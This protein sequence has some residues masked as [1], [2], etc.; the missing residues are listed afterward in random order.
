MSTLHNHKSRKIAIGADHAGFEL[1]EKLK[2][3]LTEQGHTV[4]DCG[5]FST[6]S[7]DYPVIAHQVARLI[8]GAEY[9]LGIIVDGAGI[10]SSMAANKVPGVRAALCHDISTARN[11]REHN[12]ANVLTLGAGLIGFELAKQIVDVWLIS[13]CTI[14]R[15]LRRV[16]LISDIEMGN[17]PLNIPFKN[18]HQS[19]HGTSINISNED[20]EKIANKIK[21]FLSQQ[22][23]SVS[24]KIPANCD[25]PTCNSCGQCADK[26]P[27]AVRQFINMGVS[28]V[29][30]APG[31]IGAPQ[32]IAK[33]I[34]HTLLKPEASIEDV[35]KLCQEAVEYQFSAV[36]IN[37]TYVKLSHDIT[38]GS[39]VK[40]CAV[41]GFPL[42]AH[43][44][45]IKAMEARRAIR[46]GAK[47][48]DMVINIGALKSG[49]Y[50]LVLRDIRSV[51][52]ACVDGS[53]IC[54]VI[55]EAAL[56][57]DDEKVKAC[58][59]S[60]KARAHYV[61]TSTGFGPGGATA[62]D[63]ALMKK[64]VSGTSMG[65]KAAGGIRTFEDAQKMIEAGATRIG[66][67]AGVKIVQE[68][69]SITES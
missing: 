67:S 44:P 33:Y 23:F 22:A 25:N 38:K 31:G 49:D 30:N 15:H 8:A 35:K 50:E 17:L 20:L 53:A 18:S 62:H 60:K 63:V 11:S 24:S 55:I 1:K 21:F 13:E 26:A 36:C 5:T 41:V 51:V 64:V 12:D 39:G 45:E 68:A 19:S 66:A 4:F 47:E 32:D 3:Y 27:D 54:K 34:D 48:I 2:K 28:R 9:E 40:V 37:P 43:V 61:K 29:S 6:E 65:V 57:T 16:K 7:V 56:L 69:G 42:G 10:G 14:D 59:L 46:E 58:E 52:E